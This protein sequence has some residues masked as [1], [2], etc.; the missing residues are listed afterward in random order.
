MFKGSKY[1]DRQSESADA[2]KALLAKFQSRPKADDPDVQARAAERRAVAEAR[3]IRDDERRKRKAEEAAR[4]ELERQ[5]QLRLE[6]ERKEAERL[7]AIEA[8]R[9]EA[10]LRLKQKAA[11]DARYAA[12]KA[13]K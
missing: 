12:R 9:A 11:R 4:K 3:A 7:A 5:E 13:R 6:A 10:L 2:K 8:A 1:T